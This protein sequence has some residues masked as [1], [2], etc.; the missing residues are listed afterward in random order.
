MRS[1]SALFSSSPIDSL[2]IK[3][4]ILLGF[5]ESAGEVFDI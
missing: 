2:M 4:N 3:P 5:N 1:I